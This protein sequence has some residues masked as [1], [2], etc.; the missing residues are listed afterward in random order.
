M[1]PNLV[2][3]RFLWNFSL[4][5]LSQ[6]AHIKT[7]AAEILVTV[8]MLLS[9]KTEEDVLIWIALPTRFRISGVYSLHTSKTL[10]HPS[11]RYI[12]SLTL[13]C[14]WWRVSSSG[15]LRSAS[16]LPLLP[17][18]LWPG[19]VVPIKVLSMSPIDMFRKLFILDNSTW[20][21]IIVCKLF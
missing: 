21:H 12:L 11:T 8:Y 4:W 19:E 13:N 17:G 16:S 3:C 1:F 15:C 14:I 5:H 20:Y 9:Q 10:Y 2:D 6:G 7:A 18:P